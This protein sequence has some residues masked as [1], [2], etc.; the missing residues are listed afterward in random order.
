[1]SLTNE[2]KEKIEEEERIRAEAREKYT[3]PQ[4]PVVKKKR[5]SLLTWLLLIFIGIPILIGIISSMSSSS[6]KENSSPQST[7]PV[8][9]KTLKADIKY[10]TENLT[11][12]KKED[13]AWHKC[14]IQ[15]QA[16]GALSGVNYEPQAKYDIPKKQ[17]VIPLAEFVDENGTRFNVFTTKPSYIFISCQE[18]SYEG[19]F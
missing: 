4:Q 16:G 10:D 9:E 8:Q 14:R 5:T 13:V 6:Q 12:V 11:I 17:G 19:S 2:E 15:L 18:G 7:P 3:Q 1:M